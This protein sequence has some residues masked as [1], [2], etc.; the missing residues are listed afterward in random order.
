[1]NL[2]THAK[3]CLDLFKGNKL[4]KDEMDFLLIGSVIPDVCEF[5][6]STEPRTHRQGLKFLKYLND[7]YHYLGVGMILHGEDPKGL[8]WYT[9]N[10]KGYIESKR[11]ELLKI[12][13]KY[14]KSLG[15]IDEHWA[16]HFVTEFCFDHLIM[17]KDKA[18]ALK[19]YNSFHNPNA[20]GAII[21]FANFFDVDK[22][23][24]KTLQHIVR[25]RNL[26]RYFANFSTLKGTAHNFQN[27]AFYRGIRDKR[28]QKGHLLQKLKSVTKSSWGLL[29]TK[30]RDRSLVI[31]FERC[32][33][34]VRKDHKR[35]LN[36]TEKNLRK[37]VVDYKLVR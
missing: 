35:F 12:V 11:A 26:Y 34:V 33:E 25:S 10:G 17:Q 20:D 27:F 21:N 8:D 31:M 32:T 30:L 23:R 22:R 3:V 18:V 13:R 16:V 28:Q 2:L 37:L 9:H 19:L 5:G 36:N 15:G 14:K 29:R 7:K 1:M 6:I 24:L 4:S